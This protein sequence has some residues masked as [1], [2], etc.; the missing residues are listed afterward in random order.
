MTCI[1]WEEREL[2]FKDW[3]I[4]N[5]S[6]SCE[7]SSSEDSSSEDSSSEDSSSEDSSSE[8]SSSEDSNTRSDYLDM[9]SE[10][11]K[12]YYQKK[13]DM[14]VEVW[15]VID[16]LKDAI[17]YMDLARD[18][19]VFYSPVVAS[20][21][22]GF[23]HIRGEMGKTIYSYNVKDNTIS[24]SCILSPML[25]TSHVSMWECRYHLSINLCLFLICVLLWFSFMHNNSVL[26]VFIIPFLSFYFHFRYV[27]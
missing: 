1:N 7:D 13:M 27:V 18:Y 25:P 12:T 15:K 21:L 23:I 14:S 22:G 2:F 5:K 17:F 16:D 6:T 4:T 10:I 8:D 26:Y 11:W 3:D 19:S 20:E 24:L 9:S